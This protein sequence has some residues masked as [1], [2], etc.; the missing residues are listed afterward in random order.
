MSSATNAGPSV[1]ETTG[2]ALTISPIDPTSARAGRNREKCKRLAHSNTTPTATAPSCG[3]GAA[4]AAISSTMLL[5]AAAAIYAS[6]SAADLAQGLE[7][8]RGSI[9]SGAAGDRLEQLIRAT[10]EEAA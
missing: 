10:G 9:D 4:V 1:V 5:N 8:A 2:T 7:M 3:N 6:G